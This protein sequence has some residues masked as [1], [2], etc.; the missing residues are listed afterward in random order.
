MS[1]VSDWVVNYYVTWPILWEVGY[2]VAIQSEKLFYQVP[3][4]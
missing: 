4:I 1:D 3:I 2:K